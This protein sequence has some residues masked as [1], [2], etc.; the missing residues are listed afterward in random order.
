MIIRLSLT[1]LLLLGATLSGAG[2]CPISKPSDVSPPNFND[3]LHQIALDQNSGA[4]EL[5]LTGLTTSSTAQGST[6]G[7]AIFV[8]DGVTATE[9]LVVNADTGDPVGFSVF[10]RD[11]EF[12]S[13]LRSD[14][15]DANIL[16]FV[17][18]AD[19][20]VR[21]DQPLAFILRFR[22]DGSSYTATELAME[23]LRSSLFLAG[24]VDENR[25]PHHHFLLTKVGAVDI[26]FSKSIHSPGIRPGC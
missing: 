3:R 19:R 6:C 4:G 12:E 22:Q 1:C 24:G 20:S 26:C 18:V 8:P 25:H 16:G 5:L 23:L 21:G 9:L 14:S 10:S 13:S 17:G 11:S 7:A 15:D 2:A